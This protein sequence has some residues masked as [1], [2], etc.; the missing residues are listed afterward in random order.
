MAFAPLMLCAWAIEVSV[1]WPRLA[2]RLIGHPV[3][4][5][6]WLVRQ[7]DRILNRPAWPHWA[8][9]GLGGLTTGVVVISA[10]ALAQGISIS[11][12]P[13]FPGQFLEAIVVSSLIASRSLHSHVV[14][15][16][17]PLM[18]GDLDT[19]RSAVSKIV[20][21][22]PEHLDEAGVARA[23]LESLSENMSDGVIAPVFWGLVFGLPGIAA[24]K[25]INTLDSMIGHRNDQ[26][27]AFGGVAARLDD[28]ANLVPAR[29]TGVLIA[30]AAFRREAFKAMLADARFH[31]SPNA[32][33]PE[34]AMAGALGVRLS[35]PRNYEGRTHDAPWLNGNARD[36]GP[37]DISRGVRI[38]MKACA[39]A[40]GLI[41]LLA[42]ARASS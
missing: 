12:P 19:A 37:S 4:W 23:T 9:Y 26:Y 25:A 14:D 10:C 20:G 18:T 34:A 24:Y 38:Y 6:G 8:R 29:L 31:R 27:A 36:A 22:D 42:L 15:V 33:W 11:L 41:A 21:R 16:A 7:L 3:V 30:I 40:V 17:R 13:T 32:G 5:I 2:Y 35:G 39:L 28:V 1:G